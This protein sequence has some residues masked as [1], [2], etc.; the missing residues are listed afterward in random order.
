MAD[1]GAPSIF[2]RDRAGRIANYDRGWLPYVEKIASHAARGAPL[3]EL[4]TRYDAVVGDYNGFIPSSIMQ[5][6][7]RIDLGAFD[8]CPPPE[9]LA[10]V[11]GRYVVLPTAPDTSAFFDA[12]AGVVDPEVDCIVEFGSGLGFNLARLR[13]RL[14]ESPITYIACEPT[15]HGRRAA[16]LI[17][18]A[19]PQARFEARPFDYATADLGFLDRYR[20]V[21]AFTVHSVEQMPILGEIF[22]RALLATTVA[23]CIHLEPVGWQRFTNIS[24][25]M[26]AMH[27]DRETWQSF[28]RDRQCVVEDAQLVSN[29]AMWSASCGYNTDLLSLVAGAA[30]RGEV[31]LTAL[32]Y[33]VV[34]AIPFNPSTLVGWRRTRAA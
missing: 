1:A 33:E 20:K 32:A 30:D 31:A 4:V 19:D 24:E 17:F 6:I 3:A 22:Y 28:L 14:P 21:V 15:E 2:A 29:A 16:E 8:G 25:S 9:R 23:H 10:V 34:G 12:I 11:N 13:M 5:Q 27:R 26:R 7:P 18:S